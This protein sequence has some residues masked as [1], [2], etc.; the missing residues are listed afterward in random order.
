MNKR[1]F[2]FTNYKKTT[3][4]NYFPLKKIFN[5]TFCALDDSIYDIAKWQI[6]L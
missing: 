4:R 1:F 6:N 2:V 3:E 5:I